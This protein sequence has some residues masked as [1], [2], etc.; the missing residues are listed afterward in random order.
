[1]CQ[2]L[3]IPHALCQNPNLLHFSTTF[4]TTHLSTTFSPHLGV[5][6]RLVL[7]APLAHSPLAQGLCH[8][9][10]GCA[11]QT[12]MMGM[13]VIP[14]QQRWKTRFYLL[15]RGGCPGA[16]NGPVSV[17][18]YPAGGLWAAAGLRLC[19]EHRIM[20]QASSAF[21]PPLSSSAEIGHPALP[22]LG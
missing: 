4:S 3:L 10:A 6:G 2:T 5:F 11:S 13:D 17:S 21:Q 12:S 19:C 18:G 22:V 9:V 1:M 20:L 14:D 8:R 16:I 15:S 7:W